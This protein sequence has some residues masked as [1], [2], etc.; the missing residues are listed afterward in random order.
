MTKQAKKKRSPSFINID[1]R[2]MLSTKNIALEDGLGC[3]KLN[4][5][6]IGP[7]KITEKINEVP[8]GLNLLKPMI[9]CR[10]HNTFHT[11]LLKPYTEDTFHREETLPELIELKKGEQEYEVEKILAKRKHRGETQYLEELLGYPD[12]ENTWLP[13][14]ELHHCRTLLRQFNQSRYQ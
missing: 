2:V 11:S 8:F 5:K 13:S 1:D 9:D 10:I 14:S 3:R 4:L 12:H 7:F 6:Y